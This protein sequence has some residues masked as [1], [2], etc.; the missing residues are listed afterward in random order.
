[1]CKTNTFRKGIIEMTTEKLEILLKRTK[2]G[3]HAKIRDTDL[4]TDGSTRAAALGNLLM[5]NQDVF[6]VEITTVE[7]KSTSWT[8]L[9]NTGLGSSLPR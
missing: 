7:K 3:Y 4:S 5:Q 1:M 8:G 9:P 2:D 6:G